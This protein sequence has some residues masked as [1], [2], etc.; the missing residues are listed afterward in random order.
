MDQFELIGNIV[1]A[2]IQADAIV[3]CS[4]T[5]DTNLD[6]QIQVGITVVLQ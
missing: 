5:L 3:I 2:A 6:S 1:H 4:T